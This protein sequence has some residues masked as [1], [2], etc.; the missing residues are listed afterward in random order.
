MKDY[1]I[2]IQEHN[3]YEIYQDNDKFYVCK[4]DGELIGTSNNIIGACIV[5]SLGKRGTKD[6]FKKGGSK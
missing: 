1:G 2:F 5:A 4:N 6:V 3:G